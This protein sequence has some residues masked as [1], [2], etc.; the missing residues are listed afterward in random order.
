MI[1]DDKY[2]NTIVSFWK[3]IPKEGKRELLCLGAL[4]GS[5]LVFITNKCHDF[6]NKSNNTIICTGSSYFDDIYMHFIIEASQ[7][8]HKHSQFII[9]VVSKSR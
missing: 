8:L 2:L 9:L 5:N 3:I 6:L 1:S 7:E 4:I